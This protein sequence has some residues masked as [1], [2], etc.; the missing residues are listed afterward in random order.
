[1]KF[2]FKFSKKKEGFLYMR[3]HFAVPTMGLVRSS[4]LYKSTEVNND[5]DVL[6]LIMKQ[7]KENYH[8]Q[9]LPDQIELLT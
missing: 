4:I 3:R 5:N 6:Y 1:M 8:I 2:S 9:L 7:I